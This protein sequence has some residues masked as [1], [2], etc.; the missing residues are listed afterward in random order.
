M[1]SRTELLSSRER[2][3][4]GITVTLRSESDDSIEV[5]LEP[6]TPS[7]ALRRLC[8]R[9]TAIPGGP[10][11]IQTISTPDTIYRDL[12]Q[13]LLYDPAFTGVRTQQ[14]RNMHAPRYEGWL[15]QDV[16]RG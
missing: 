8:T 13:P 4:Y 6:G 12:T 15:V 3:R 16:P 11:R 5:V 9:W 2:A 14:P 7:R 10:W 1:T